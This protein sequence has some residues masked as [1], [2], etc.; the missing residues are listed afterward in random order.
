MSS[1]HVFHPNLVLARYLRHLRGAAAD[2]QRPPGVT[3]QAGDLPGH[4][5][6]GVRV[7]DGQALQPAGHDGLQLGVG[8]RLEHLPSKM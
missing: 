6:D 4:Q 1:G 8:V 7:E 3:G 2:V 5:L